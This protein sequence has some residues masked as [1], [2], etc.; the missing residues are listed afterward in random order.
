MNTPSRRKGELFRLAPSERQALVRSLAACDRSGTSRGGSCAAERQGT[1]S[2]EHERAAE[3]RRR[4]EQADLREAFEQHLQRNPAFELCQRRPQAMVDAAA[5]LEVRAAPAADVEAIRIAER[6]RVS[7]GRTQPD[8]EGFPLSYRVSTTPGLGTAN[9]PGLRACAVNMAG[10]DPGNLL[11]LRSEGG[12]WRRSLY[13]GPAA[14]CGS[15]DPTQ[16]RACA[17][18]A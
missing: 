6:F 2:P 17:C 1:Q 3:L 7:V 18:T 9:A 16:M 10:A 4:A 12:K 8:G 15:P 14:V 5:E 13:R 11:P